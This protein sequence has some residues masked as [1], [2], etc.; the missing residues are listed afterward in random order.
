MTKLDLNQPFHAGELTAQAR[1]GVGDVAA[2]AGGF[3]RDYLP[4]EHQAFHT[5]LPFLLVSGADAT[6]QT[7]ITLVE[8]P[9][10]FARV[11]HPRLI[12]LDTDIDPTDPLADA[13]QTGTQIGVLGIELASRRRNRFSGMMR[14]K[15]GNYSIDI[16]QTFGNCPQYIHERSWTRVTRTTTVQAQRTDALSDAQIALIGVADTMFIG[17]GHQGETGAASNGY[18]ASHRGGAPGFVHVVDGTH[19]Q[20]PDYVG[21]NFFNTIGNLVSNP[22]IGLLFVDFKT[23]GLLHVTGRADIDW[24]AQNAHDPDAWST[25]RSIR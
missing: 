17:S 5:S 6:G 4:Q 1:A 24:A 2:W 12:E 8:G 20:I 25:S 19:L 14:A 18:D 10:G 22:R 21:N 13:F 7:W 23:G 3:I 11:P 15:D 9:E 16:E